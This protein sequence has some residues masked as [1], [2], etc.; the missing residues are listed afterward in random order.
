MG[1]DLTQGHNA[2]GL[3][4]C[5]ARWATRV[6]PTQGRNGRGQPRL[7]PRR[8]ME[9]VNTLQAR[10]VA[11]L[12]MACRW[13]LHSLH[14]KNWWHLGIPPG[15]V[16]RTKAHSSS[17]A[18]VR[19]PRWSSVGEFDGG[20]GWHLQHQKENDQYSLK[21]REGGRRLQIQ[22]DRWR[23]HGWSG[24]KANRGL[25]GRW[26]GLGLGRS[27]A[28]K[29]GEMGSAWRCLRLGQLTW[30]DWWGLVARLRLTPT[31]VSATCATQWWGPAANISGGCLLARIGVRREWRVRRGMLTGGSYPRDLNEFKKS[32]FRSNLIRSK[33]DLPWLKIF[34]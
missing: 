1:R 30:T 34:G 32:K 28:N 27:C 22:W 21:R 4:A 18:M 2:R 25:G 7:A 17:G 13:P 15:M 24:Q 6:G 8:A 3:A 11:P 31:T 29:R 33:S 5:Y 23:S 16:F 26:Q 12:P 9:P 19:W 14:R 10:A 20:F